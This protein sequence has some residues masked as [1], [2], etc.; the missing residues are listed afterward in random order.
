MTN[1]L[2][3]IVKFAEFVAEKGVPL[4]MQMVDAF[5]DE[6]PELKEP[7]PE[8]AQKD[9]DKHIDQLIDEKFSS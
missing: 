1:T 3:W 9:I 2:D 7:P 6:H 8:A 4:G 5:A